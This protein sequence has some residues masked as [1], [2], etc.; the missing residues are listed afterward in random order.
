MRLDEPPFDAPRA[1]ESL[2]RW[3][4]GSIADEISEPLGRVYDLLV[5]DD[6]GV[7]WW[8][9]GYRD[10]REHPDFGGDDEGRVRRQEAPCPE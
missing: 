5:A 3:L 2:E 4:A 7:H 1:G 9:H 6:D 10:V 8:G